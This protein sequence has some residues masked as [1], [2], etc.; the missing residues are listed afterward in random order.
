MEPDISRVNKSGQLDVLTTPLASADTAAAKGPVI[1]GGRR[2]RRLHGKGIADQ[3][4][5]ASDR[6]VAIIYN[7]GRQATCTEAGERLCV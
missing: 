1:T 3:H 4:T 6:M 5:S 7:R 2:D